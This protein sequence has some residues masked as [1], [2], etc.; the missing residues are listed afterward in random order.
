MSHVKLVVYERATG[1]IIQTMQLPAYMLEDQVIAENHAILDVTSLPFF[2]RTDLHQVN[3]ETLTVEERT[4]ALDEVKQN[5]TYEL[6]NACV[7][8]ITGGFLLDGYYYGS[9]MQDQTN[10]LLGGNS[11]A[12]K[13]AVTLTGPWEPALLDSNEITALQNAFATHRDTQRN[14][15]WGLL[16]QVDSATTAEQVQQILW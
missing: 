6:R 3:T 15:L 8:A 14:K 7:L 10:M 11:L 9:S 2:V 5:K 4:V 1:K 12:V 16:E 13:R